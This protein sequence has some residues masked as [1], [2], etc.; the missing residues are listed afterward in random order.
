MKCGLQKSPRELTAQEPSRP[1]SNAMSTTQ[2]PTD[3]RPR[4]SQGSRSHKSPSFSVPAKHPGLSLQEGSG[5]IWR[6]LGPWESIL[7]FW[8][9]MDQTKAISIVRERWHLSS[10][11]HASPELSFSEQSLQTKWDH[12]LLW[13]PSPYPLYTVTLQLF[14]VELPE[15]LASTDRAPRAPPNKAQR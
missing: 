12:P 9:H 1:Q 7:H 5:K 3:L 6:L 2:S 11:W 4:P 10:H 13:N 14:S 15:V 8:A